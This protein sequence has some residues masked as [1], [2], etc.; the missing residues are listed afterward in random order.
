M[1]R[2]I[3]RSS[4]RLLRARR[5]SCGDGATVEGSPDCLFAPDAV[6]ARAAPEAPLLPS[7]PGAGLGA[8]GV[9]GVEPGEA[10]A[11]V[12]EGP[13]VADGLPLVEEEPD[14]EEEPLPV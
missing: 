9:P 7:R 1:P 5:S 14:D 11:G 6:P 13:L 4:S 10:G 8:V 2:L 3:R 12:T